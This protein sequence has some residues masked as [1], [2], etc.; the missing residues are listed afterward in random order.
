M[1][2]VLQTIVQ[3]HRFVK[4]CSATIGADTPL[5]EALVDVLHIL[6]NL[7]PANTCQVS[8]VVP[9]IQIYYGTTSIVDRKLFSI[10]H[11][12]ESQR[13]TSV[14]SL[15]AHWDASPDGSSSNCLEAIQT[16]DPTLLLRTCTQFPVWRKVE[17][18]V[19][20]YTDISSVTYDPV[21]VILIFA[22]M[23]ESP[24]QSTF[25]WIELFRTNIVGVLITAL[26]A[27]DDHVRELSLC[28]LAA[29]WK[30]LEVCV[31]C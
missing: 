16:L 29:L 26:S 23:L 4:H 30:L 13:K 31:R 5:R 27:K 24:P 9:L 12:F 3:S 15:F 17:D 10:F 11:L 28:A 14:A 25:A 20:E 21:F 18:Q 22:H 7:H 6:F 1:N 19:T 8:H 2:R